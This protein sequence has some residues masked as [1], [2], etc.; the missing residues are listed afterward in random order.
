M[1]A[2]T[3]TQQATLDFLRNYINEHGIAPSHAELAEGMG[4][5]SSNNSQLKLA[6]LQKKGY[7]TIKPGISRGLTLNE[8]RTLNIPDVNDINYWVDGLFQHLKYQSDVYKA[9]ENAGIIKK[10]GYDGQ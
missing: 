5:K 9:L 8:T 4:W 1:E 10:G 2:L 7:L 3:D 6:I